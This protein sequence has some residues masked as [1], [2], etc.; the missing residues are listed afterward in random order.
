MKRRTR[1]PVLTLLGLLSL[2]SLFGRAAST[3]SAASTQAHTQSNSSQR[4]IAY[5][6]QWGIYSGFFE[7]NLI[8]SGTGARLT[9]LDYAFSNI[10]PDLQCVSGD[11]WADFQRPFAA[12]ESV[13]GQDDM[14]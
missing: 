4:V 12:S 6:T 13:N 7:K 3:A 2:L 1:L 14:A 9:T 8:A 11:T 5:F 10:S